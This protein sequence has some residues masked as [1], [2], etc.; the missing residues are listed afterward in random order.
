MLQTVGTWNSYDCI[1]VSKHCLLRHDLIVPAPFDITFGAAKVS[2][3]RM[4]QRWLSLQPNS[5]PAHTQPSG[6][7]NCRLAPGSLY[8]PAACFWVVRA[9]HY[10]QHSINIS[11]LGGGASAL[12]CAPALVPFTPCK[13]PLVF[14]RQCLRTLLT[15]VSSVWV[16]ERCNDV[17]CQNICIPL[18]HQW[19][20]RS[21]TAQGSAL[22]AN[23]M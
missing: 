21:T 22:L 4:K 20:V 11:R 14:S 18:C 10:G 7:P 15:I 23:K 1:P 2:Q 3:G 6:L 9:G 5:Q 19:Q 8:K 12:L 17:V 16:C 13:P